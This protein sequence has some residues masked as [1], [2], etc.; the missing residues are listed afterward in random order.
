MR[1]EKEKGPSKSL[2]IYIY[3]LS[4]DKYMSIFL[5]EG[6]A[7]FIVGRTISNLQGSRI[8]FASCE[9]RIGRLVKAASSV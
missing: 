5:K 2:Y 7:L 1:G 8:T 6:I 9:P 3:G 4:Q